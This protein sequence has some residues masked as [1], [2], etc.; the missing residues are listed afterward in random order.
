MPTVI[1]ART[2]P[3]PPAAEPR[4]VSDRCDETMSNA[5]SCVCASG[6]SPRKS[7]EDAGMKAYTCEIDYADRDGGDRRESCGF[8]CKIWKGIKVVAPFAIA[9]IA[10][11]FIYKLMSPKKP[12]LAAPPDKCPNG[13]LPPCAQTCTP[14]LSLQSTGV[15]GCPACP[16]PQVSN[17]ST[18]QCTTP[19]GGGTTPTLITC[20]DGATR[21]A[22]LDACPDY[23][24]WNGQS[25]K[26]PMNCPPAPAPTAAPAGVNQ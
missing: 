26:N 1:A 20:P 4:P 3:P 7:G 14:P 9:G 22:N 6:A 10:G 25:Y 15:C 11:Y 17:A 8:F 24:C 18:C 2:P 13:S 19:N 21:A 23:P 5:P 12:T 16:P